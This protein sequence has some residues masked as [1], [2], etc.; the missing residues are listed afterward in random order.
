MVIGGLAYMAK[1]FT[2]QHVL[3]EIPQH[4]EDLETSQ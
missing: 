4:F 2:C 1:Q 3:R